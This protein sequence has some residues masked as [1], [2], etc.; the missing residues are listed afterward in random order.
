MAHCLTFFS[1]LDVDCA[2]VICPRSLYSHYTSLGCTPIYDGDACCPTRYD[3]QT[4]LILEERRDQNSINPELKCQYKGQLY[5]IGGPVPEAA[6]PSACRATCYCINA[7]GTPRINC[8]SIEC[9]ENFGIRPPGKENC[10]LLYRKGS[11]CAH[12][13]F[14]SGGKWFF[15]FRILWD[16]NFSNPI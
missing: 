15:N 8:A 6:S 16:Y 2:H 14:C 10:T 4:P 7:S 5:S 9:P 1:S 13:Y 11:C 12:D 3:C